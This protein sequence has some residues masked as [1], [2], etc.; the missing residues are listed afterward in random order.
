[1]RDISQQNG[2]SPNQFGYTL[3][4]YISFSTAEL[5]LWTLTHNQYEILSYLQSP[6]SL[7][8]VTKAECQDHQDSSSQT[9]EAENFSAS[10]F[11]LQQDV[12]PWY[13][14]LLISP[15][16]LVRARAHAHKLSLSAVKVGHGRWSGS[17]DEAVTPLYDNYLGLRL[18]VRQATWQLMRDD[19]E[20]HLSL[21]SM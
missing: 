1:L 21:G 11:A 10:S 12:C 4:H 19:S 15:S 3:Y 17:R 9:V 20:N 16:L 7:F 14:L 6:P 13:P 18:L 2:F 5:S 8:P